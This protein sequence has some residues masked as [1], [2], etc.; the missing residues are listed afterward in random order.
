M[1]LP[2]TKRL[3]AFCIASFSI[4][5]TVGSLVLTVLVKWIDNG[6]GVSGVIISRN[7]CILACRRVLAC[8]DERVENVTS[9]GRLAYFDCSAGSEEFHHQVDGDQN[10]Q[11]YQDD[12]NPRQ[13][14]S[15][16]PAER[17]SKAT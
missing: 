13:G 8:R 11:E 5:T 4:L 15:R 10:S 9:N 16:L 17:F 6:S 12:C 7:L 14:L 1:P 3:A 2:D